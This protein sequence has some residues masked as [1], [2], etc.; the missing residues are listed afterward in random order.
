[1]ASM[2]VLVSRFL[3]N[4]TQ[5]DSK[6]KNIYINYN[7]YSCMF[8]SPQTI[9]LMTLMYLLNNLRLADTSG[10]YQVPILYKLL[11]R[12]YRTVLLMKYCTYLLC[13]ANLFIIR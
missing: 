3:N 5:I 8:H 13:F 4:Y 11:T 7:L 6:K 1:M 10:R 9:Q 12:A 2:I